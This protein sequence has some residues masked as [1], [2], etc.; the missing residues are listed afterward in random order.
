MYQP[1]MPK[2][3][4]IHD[5]CVLLHPKCWRVLKMQTWHWTKTFGSKPY[6]KTTTK[7][8]QI[9]V[10]MLDSQFDCCQLMCWCCFNTR[11]TVCLQRESVKPTV[12]WWRGQLH[13]SEA[14]NRTFLGSHQWFEGVNVTFM[15]LYSFISSL[16][17]ASCV[18][19]S[20]WCVNLNHLCLSV[21]F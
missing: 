11:L 2:S 5:F 13:P 10:L 12:S 3:G 21:M 19:N 20:Q 18:S 9:Y 14:G 7:T 1:M 8:K 15:G 6:I 4:F 17:A 16:L